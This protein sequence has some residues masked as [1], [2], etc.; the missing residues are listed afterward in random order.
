MHNVSDFLR[1]VLLAVLVGFA[2]QSVDAAES[3]FVSEV[4]VFLACVVR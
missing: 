1:I 4:R 3:D 2:S